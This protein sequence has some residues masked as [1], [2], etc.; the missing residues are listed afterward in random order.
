[1]WF[2]YFISQALRRDGRSLGAIITS[3]TIQSLMRQMLWYGFKRR[4]RQRERERERERE[5]DRQTETENF[6]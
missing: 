4:E 3:G 5:N 1:M 2:S 6:L